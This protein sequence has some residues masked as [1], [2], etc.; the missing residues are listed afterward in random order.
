MNHDRSYCSM[1]ITCGGHCG[2]LIAAFRCALVMSD[3]GNLLLATS[4]SIYLLYRELIC[5][6]FV[7]ESLHH[8]NP[9]VPH[10]HHPQSE[11]NIHF[12]PVI[13]QQACSHVRT[14]SQSL[15]SP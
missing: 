14:D 5:L 7:R 11:N 12:S 4:T 2:I 3:A 1:Y 9:P 15:A 10:D 8:I 6:R 13:R